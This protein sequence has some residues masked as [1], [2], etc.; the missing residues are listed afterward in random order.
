MGQVISIPK[1]AA[2]ALS[3]DKDNVFSSVPTI[4]FSLQRNRQM[5]GACDGLSAPRA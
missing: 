1:R 4:E 3:F 5:Q 2:V